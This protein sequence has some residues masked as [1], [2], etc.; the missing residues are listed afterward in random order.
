MMNRMNLLEVLIWFEK[1]FEIE[2]K[3]F[4]DDSVKAT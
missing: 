1:N 4:L 2:F 3:N